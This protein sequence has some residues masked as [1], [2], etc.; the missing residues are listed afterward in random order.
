MEQKEIKSKIQK[1]DP[2]K[3]W[4]DDYD[5]RFYLISQL[6]NLKKKI[7]LDLGGGIGIICSEMDE[8]NF[9]INLDLSFNDLNTCKK[10]LKSNIEKICASMTHLPFKENLFDT[11][12]CSHL[13]EVAKTIDLEQKNIIE[14]DNVYSFPTVEKVLAA[15]QP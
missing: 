10:N 14:K 13:I 9:I 11:V 15:N 3:W 12:I 4:G 7:V 5:V 2:T 6:E 8:S 1:I